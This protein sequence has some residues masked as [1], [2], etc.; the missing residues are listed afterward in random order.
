MLQVKC[1]KTVTRLG[2]PHSKV[3]TVNQRLTHGSQDF[4]QITHHRILFHQRRRLNI[5]ATSGNKWPSKLVVP[6]VMIPIHFLSTITSHLKLSVVGYKTGHQDCYNQFR[7]GELPNVMCDL[8]T[9][10]QSEMQV[11]IQVGK[12]H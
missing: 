2:W 5:W 7:N 3:G 1:V 12:V 4:D 6:N 11:L 9:N 8:A 10:L